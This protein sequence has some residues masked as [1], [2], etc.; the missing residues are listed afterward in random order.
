MEGINAYSRPSPDGGIIID[1]EAMC[2]DLITVA[3]ASGATKEEFL[4]FV[5][6]TFDEVR[7]DIRI[8]KRAKN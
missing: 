5:A 4:E 8:P 6:K 1:V 7:V 3:K 2:V